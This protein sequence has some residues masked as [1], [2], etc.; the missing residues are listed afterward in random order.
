M[1]STFQDYLVFQPVGQN[2]FFVTLA[3][4][5]WSVNASVNLLT[6]VLTPSNIPPALIPMP[7]DVFPYWD[8]YRPGH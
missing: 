8:E 3:T 6:G 4:N 5:G 2:S 1:D 7:S